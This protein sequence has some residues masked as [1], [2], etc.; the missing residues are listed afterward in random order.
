VFGVD[1]AIAGLSQGNGIVLLLAVAFVLGLRHASDPDHLV[2]VSTLVATERDR[3]ACRASRLG[4]AWGL[5]HASTVVAFGIP[6]VFF[7]GYLPE[8]AQQIAEALVG[9]MIIAL[10][11]RLLVRWRRRGVHVHEHSHDGMVHRHVHTHVRE[12]HDHGHVVTRSPVQAFGV[13]LVH[14]VGGSAAV[15]LLLLA[16]ISS[17]LEALAALLLFAVATAVSMAV[18]SLGLGY[19]LGRGGLLVRVRAAVPALAGL[20]FVFGACYLVLSLGPIG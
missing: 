3:P 19:A 1:H 4:L 16:S 12:R 17:R 13:G 9:V 2:A 8:V 15:G 11:I 6:I 10:A 20:S 18:L 5:G 14:G 7:D